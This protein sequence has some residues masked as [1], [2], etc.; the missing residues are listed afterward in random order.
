MICRQ[1][2]VFEAC[3]PGETKA[4]K[5]GIPLD[6]RHMRKR[7]GERVSASVPRFDQLKAAWSVAPAP[8]EIPGAQPLGDGHVAWN[9][10]HFQ[11]WGCLFLGN[12]T[13]MVALLLVSL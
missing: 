3:T 5:V 12:P 10:S 11:R 7:A 13:K 2:C 4:T 1:V 6:R 8:H 9:T